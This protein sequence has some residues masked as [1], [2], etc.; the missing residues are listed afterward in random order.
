MS[1]LRLCVLGALL[2]SCVTVAAPPLRILG[3][4][5]GQKPQP[6]WVYARA[7]QKVTLHAELL[8]GVP[9]EGLRWYRIEPSTRAVDNTQ[10]AFHW[11]K[12]AYATEELTHCRGKRACEVDVIPR[13]LPRNAHLEGLGTMAFQLSATLPDGTVLQTP[14]AESIDRGGL[15]R[16]VFRVAIRKDDSY[17]GYL[18]ELA[19]TPYIFGSAGAEGNHQADLLVGSDCADLAVYGI[20]RAGRTDVPYV[21]TWTIEKHAPLVVQATARSSSGAYADAR[22]RSITSAREGDLVLFPGTRHVG[23]LWEDRPPKG[24]LD[25]GDLLLHTC[26]A[27]PTVEPLGTAACA[28]LPMRVLRFR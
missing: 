1:P 16:R 28:S 21:S 14:G 3:S 7:S 8:R 15:S 6:A 19:N 17:L 25:E 18:S 9:D 24:V 20:R 4:I 27:P 23:V 13:H 11:A 10:P 26:W 5:E 12:I 2:W 22:G